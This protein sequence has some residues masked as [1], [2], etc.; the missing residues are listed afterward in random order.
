MPNRLSSETS[1]YL[2]QHADNP[3]DWHPWGEA[4]LTLARQQDKPI[5]LSI[6]YSACHWCHVMAHES[7]ENVATAAVMNEHFINIKVDREERPDLDQIYQ[8]AHGMLTGRSG[9]WPLT[10]FLTP[11]QVPFFGGTYFPDTPRFGLPAFRDLLP[12]I[13]QYY[14]ENRAEISLQS[15]A[16]LDRLQRDMPQAASREAPDDGPIDE[17]LSQLQ[18]SFDWDNGGFGTAPKFPNPALL[19]LCLREGMDGNRDTLEMA[20]KALRSMALGG[21]YDQLGGGFSRYSIDQHWMIPHFEKM[22]YDNAQLLCLYSDAWRVTGEPLFARVVEETVA[23]AMREMCA[24]DGLFYSSLDADSEGR[25]GK[26]YVWQRGEIQAALTAQEYALIELLFGL[27]ATPNFENTAWHLYIVHD[28][29][30]AANLAGI[31]IEAAIELLASARRKLFELRE[32]RVRPG[33]DDK[34]L[35]SWN[36]LMIKALARAG[37]VF[38]NDGWITAAQ[39][40]V[41]AIH[42]TLWQNNRLLATS[43][44]GQAHLNAYLDDYAYLL[45]ALLELLQARYRAEYWVFAQEVA[46]ALLENFHDDRDGGFYFTSHDHEAL[47]HRVKN[48]HDNATPAGNGIAALA[49]QRLAHL[50]GR[51][52]LLKAATDTLNCFQ[53]MLQNSPASCPSLLMALREAILPPS[54]VIVRGEGA[55]LAHWR[56]VLERQYRPHTLLLFLEHDIGDL[57]TILDKPMQGRVNAWVCHGVNCLPAIDNLNDLLV[58]V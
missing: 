41:D 20:L 18:A 21:I 44:N 28:A 35:G 48:G 5:L 24:P 13:A 2:L 46:E 32:K 49:L 42:A 12:R 23:W 50:A 26:F 3:V 10:M 8:S 54:L 52:D 47:I 31:P 56:H 45:D 57:P 25:E 51:S 27:E 1:P 39:Q 17:T 15:Q 7:F 16:M 40:A 55:E 58:V 19:E 37:R 14:R 34:I 33:R 53:G 29:E 22:L 11:Q 43:R 6:G 38:R 4:A 9:G 36:A 30:T